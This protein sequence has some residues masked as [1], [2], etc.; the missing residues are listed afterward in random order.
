M[1]SS[2]MLTDVT[3]PGRG[4]FLR[5]LVMVELPGPA[6][7]SAPPGVA[8]KR[9]LMSSVAWCSRKIDALSRIA[10]DGT[11]LQA[12][13]RTMTSYPNAASSPP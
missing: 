10:R 13:K 7:P 1:K 6:G 12:R 11:T 3:P 4:V 2:A 5:G 8:R 9:T